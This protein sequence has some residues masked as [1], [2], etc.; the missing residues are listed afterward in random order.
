[1]ADPGQMLQA[2]IEGQRAL[3]D[4]IAQQ[5]QLMNQQAMM[6]TTLQESTR[7]QIEA[8]QRQ[9]AE[10]V[11][12]VSAATTKAHRTGV[13]DVKSIGKPDILQGKKDDIGRQWKNWSFR[14][15]IWLSSQF[16]KG[17]E[18]LDWARECTEPI[19][20]EKIDDQSLV[21]DDIKSSNAQLR[22]ALELDQ[23]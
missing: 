5:A 16:D 4:V 15:E 14:F 12:A 20:M 1:M 23:R 10:S 22:V 9:T 7:A 13:V 18:I 19:T 3:Q 6:M 21:F 11:A 8:V 2:L 17:Q